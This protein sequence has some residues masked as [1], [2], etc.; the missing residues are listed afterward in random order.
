[1]NVPRLSAPGMP[2]EG[3]ESLVGLAFGVWGDLVKLTPFGAVLDS[4]KKGDVIRHW[5]VLWQDQWRRQLWWCG[6]RP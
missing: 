2:I 1:M 6:L 3:S 4:Q 5:T